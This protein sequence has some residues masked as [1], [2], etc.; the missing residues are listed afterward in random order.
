M[1]WI[2]AGAAV[3]IAG[4]GTSAAAGR[5]RGPRKGASGDQ[6]IV[7]IASGDGR[8]E[9]LVSALQAT[10]L[11][12]VLNSEED[13][14]TVFAPTDEAFGELEAI[15][16]PPELT[17]ILLYH[18]TE[19]RRYAASVVNAPEVEMLNGGTVSVDGTNLN[20]DQADIVG[21]NIEANNGVIHV[22]DGVLLP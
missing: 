8:F 21:T 17:N 5:G 1:R 20:G 9:T 11:D 19:G 15:P 10:G 13:Q 18:V 2:G 22:I 7:D 4:V 3:G 6:T 16:A 14:F 12:A